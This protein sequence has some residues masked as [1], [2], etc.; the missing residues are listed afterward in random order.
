M[1]TYKNA[2][3]DTSFWASRFVDHMQFIE[4][5]VQINK[6]SPEYDSKMFET[7][8]QNI[9][10]LKNIPELIQQ[11]QAFQKQVQTQFPKTS[12]WYKL[13]H[14]MMDET[15][16]FNRMFLKKDF[17]YS[18]SFCA[19]EHAEANAFLLCEMPKLLLGNIPPNLKEAN[20]KTKKLISKF[21]N[22]SQKP[23]ATKY[24]KYSNIHI[25]H[26]TD[27]IRIVLPTLPLED[28]VKQFVNALVT[29]EI[30]EAMWCRKSIK[31]PKS[32]RKT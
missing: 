4:T 30:K 31:R 29:H 10:N 7:S 19:K 23:D 20:V 25:H 21:K 9:T 11:T 17:T 32:S 27:F 6:L 14:H 5:I 26:A 8:W 13:L 1:Q 28:N 12:C 16:E 24:L 2:V 15:A 18:I 3:Q 22:I